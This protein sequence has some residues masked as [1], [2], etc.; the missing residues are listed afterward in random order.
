MLR[1][2]A[3]AVKPLSKIANGATLFLLLASIVNSSCFM[4]YS[5]RGKAKSPVGKRLSQAANKQILCLESE[6]FTKIPPKI[7]FGRQQL[8][9]LYSICPLPQFESRGDGIVT[10]GR[11]WTFGVVL[12][13]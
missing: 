5:G 9:R 11:T 7:L 1:S 13:L 3:Q 6:P 2:L 12:G 8:I 10:P 4:V